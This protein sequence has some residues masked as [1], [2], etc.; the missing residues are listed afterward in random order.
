MSAVYLLLMLFGI[1]A[2]VSVFACAV[3]PEAGDKH[4]GLTHSTRGGTGCLGVHIRCEQK[5]A[6]GE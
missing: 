4:S 5:Q 3:S 1:C 6:L 2:S